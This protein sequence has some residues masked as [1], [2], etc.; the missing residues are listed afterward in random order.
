[1]DNV[2]VWD[3][4]L[5]AEQ[6]HTNINLPLIGNETGLV[7]Y[8]N[9]NEGSGNVLTDITSNDNNGIVHGGAVWSEEIP[10][11]GCNDSN[12]NISTSYITS[13]FNCTFSSDRQRKR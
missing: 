10:I 8:W 1:M 4:A 12:H 13:I 11:F 6:I 7:G 5:S 9:F 3:S 2:Q